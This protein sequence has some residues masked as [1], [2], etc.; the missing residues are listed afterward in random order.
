MTKQQFVTKA[1]EVK[2]EEVK[3]EVKKLCFF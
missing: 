3:E 2:E 1:Q